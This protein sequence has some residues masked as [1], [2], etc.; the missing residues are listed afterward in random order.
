MVNMADSLIARNNVGILLK[1]NLPAPVPA[2]SAA[3]S[4]SRAELLAYAVRSWNDWLDA[5]EDEDPIA[6]LFSNARNKR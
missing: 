4:I 2:A 3:K 1:L 5:D 6:G